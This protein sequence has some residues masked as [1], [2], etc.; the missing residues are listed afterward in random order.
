MDDIDYIVGN[1]IFEN[2]SQAQ[3]A[4]REQRTIDT[5][6]EKTN[7]D[8]PTVCIELYQRLVA[9]KTFKTQIGYQFLFELRDFILTEFNI[10]EINLYRI[11]VITPNQTEKKVKRQI[12]EELEEKIVCLR[13][14]Q[15]RLIL[16]LCILGSVII[17][18]FIICATNKNVGY[19]NT[20]NKI[21]D[22]YSSWES[23]LEER[24]AII[25][26]KEAE[27]QI[28]LENK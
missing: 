6:K 23:S 20:E 17:A 24:E 27:L 7:F 19:I 4:L 15:T 22:K 21:L 18:M 25:A 2:N 11:P 8:N 3:Q 9:K 16:A 28:N 14:T 1:Y 5:I 26:E 12:S 10:N 13:Q